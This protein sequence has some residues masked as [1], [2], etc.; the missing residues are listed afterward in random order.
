MGKAENEVSDQIRSF[1]EKKGFKVFRMQSGRFRGAGGWV[2][3]NPVGTP[4]LLAIEPGTGRALCIEAK[5]K[6]GEASEIQ[7]KTIEELRK[8]GAS[9]LIAYSLGDVIQALEIV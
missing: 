9:A 8:L 7:V 4:D 6:E 3:M 1:L 2:T 5:T